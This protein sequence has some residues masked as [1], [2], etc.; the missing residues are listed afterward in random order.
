MFITILGFAAGVFVGYKFPQQVEQAVG[1]AKKLFND[2]KGMITKEP[3]RQGP[4]N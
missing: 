1:S 3:P 2:I 4:S